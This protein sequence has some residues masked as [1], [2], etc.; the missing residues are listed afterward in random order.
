VNRTTAQ[1]AWRRWQAAAGP[2][3]GWSIC[4][5]LLSPEV[6]SLP[7]LRPQ[8]DA[9]ATQLA[10]AMRPWL[11]QPGGTLCVLD[12]Q[13]TLGV[14]VAARLADAAHPVLV[15]P[16]WPYVEAILPAEQ[17][18]AILLAEVRTL[19][20]P[21]RLPNALFVLDSERSRA[22]PFREPGDHRAD[23]RFPPASFELPDLATLRAR[24][25]R[26]IHRFSHA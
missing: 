20:P 17:L 11:A 22:I 15:L 23:N 14:Q 3:Q 10:A 26:R 12:L 16:R 7:R 18:L 4:P 24:D 19:P 21:R 13:P 2:W 1:D 5:T 25:I 8:H 9:R 6:K